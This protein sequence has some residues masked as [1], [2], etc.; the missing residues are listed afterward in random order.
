VEEG[1]RFV[2]SQLTNAYAVNPTSQWKGYSEPPPPP[3]PEWGADPCGMRD[4]LTE[5]IIERRHGASAQAMLRRLG[6][7]D[8]D[9]GPDGALLRLG[10]GALRKTLGIP[11]A[12]ACHRNQTS[13]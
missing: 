1:G 4:P 8:A 9:D 7:A 3:V 2:L 12:P 6:E 10:R 11:G 5:A 13:F